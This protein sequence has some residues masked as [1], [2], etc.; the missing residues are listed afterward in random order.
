MAFAFKGNKLH[1]HN[2]RKILCWHINDIIIETLL[3]YFDSVL[4]L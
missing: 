1:Q 4:L 2:K 3:D